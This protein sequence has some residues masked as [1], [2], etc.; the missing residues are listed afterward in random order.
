MEGGLLESF[1]LN[2]F[3]GSNFATLRSVHSLLDKGKSREKSRVQLCM[4][5]PWEDGQSGALNFP[6]LLPI[7]AGLK[8][9]E[10]VQN[11]L[12]PLEYS[13]AERE[14]ELHFV[15]CEWEIGSERECAIEL[16][17]N[18]LF[19]KHRSS[20][21]AGERG[22]RKRGY[23]ALLYGPMSSFGTEHTRTASQQKTSPESA[24][25]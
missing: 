11:P 19:Q 23:S 14:R 5:A 15:V 9:A 22:W 4:P 7:K 20:V 8:P 2:D 18:S 25:I 3:G 12:S 16:G 24:P 21:L 6:R 10:A 13:C 17:L 1:F